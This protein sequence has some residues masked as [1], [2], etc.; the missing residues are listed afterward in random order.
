MATAKET[1]EEQSTE[2]TFY[3]RVGHRHEGDHVRAG[4]R[5]V[6]RASRRRDGG[7]LAAGDQERMEFLRD[8]Q[9]WQHY[10]AT[11]AQVLLHQRL[12]HGD[13]RVWNPDAKIRNRILM[14]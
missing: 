12:R 11:Q 8:A 5:P 2:Q 10:L 13:G 6:S 4:Q 7:T 3:G 9:A 14:P 1:D